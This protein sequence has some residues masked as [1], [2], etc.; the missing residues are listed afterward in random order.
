MGMSTRGGFALIASMMA[1]MA[2]AAPVAAET[3]ATLA[4]AAPTASRPAKRR[5]RR[6][7]TA[8]SPRYRSK[9]KAARR[10]PKPNRLH[11]SRR[12]RRKHRR[13]KAA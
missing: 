5:A 7:A 1:S 13:S 10:V 11:I 6:Y 4:E 3:R 9:A 12:T 2:L 8:S